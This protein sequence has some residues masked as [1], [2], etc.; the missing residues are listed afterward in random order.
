[1][2]E[3]NRYELKCTFFIESMNKLSQE[4]TFNNVIKNYLISLMI[5]YR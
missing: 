1:M 3:L 2:L 4:I 5:V